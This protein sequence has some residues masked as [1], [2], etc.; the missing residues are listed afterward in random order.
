MTP[1]R[2]SRPPAASVRCALLVLAGCAPLGLGCGRTAPAAADPPPLKSEP[3]AD[4]SFT[5][6]D[7]EQGKAGEDLPEMSRFAWESFVALNW[8]A[9]AGER[10]VPDPDNPFRDTSKPVVWGTWKSLDELFPRTKDRPD[11]EPTPWDSFEAEPVVGVF[12]D[13]AKLRRYR[14]PDTDAKEFG[15][16]KV[17]GQLSSINQAT[18][19]PATP[20]SPLVAQTGKLVRYEVRVNKAEYNHVLGNG[21]Y[22][23]ENLIKLA[24]GAGDF[25]TCSAH[26]KAAWMEL[27]DT[28]RSGWDRLYHTRAL[29]VDW[30]TD[31]KSVLT[32]R[33]VGLV[34]LHIVRRTPSRRSWVWATF[35]HVDNL[36]PPAGGGGAFFTSNP[37]RPGND[38]A[39]NDR[40][41]NKPL[42]PGQPIP[43]LDRTEVAR[44]NEIPEPIKRANE[45]FRSQPQLRGTVW[46]NYQLVGVQWA[47]ALDANGVLSD[48]GSPDQAIVRMIPKDPVANVTLETFRQ[49][50]SCLR[51]HTQSL[52]FPFVFYPDA[53]AFPPPPE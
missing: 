21:Y 4:A 16:R 42:T 49:K 39:A 7:P 34:G 43:C 35:E 24:E 41:L 48:D 44:V 40:D 45:E 46:R 38:P 3:P 10:G 36:V 11:A 28:N 27:S 6:G 1:L 13:K 2:E 8:P 37:D 51:C 32:E 52:R 29:L 25:P 5:P 20:G 18:T 23:R 50:N 53:R 14:L 17:L 30:D 12:T 26:V 9:K 47:R 31:H 33:E 22:R 15:R 19:N